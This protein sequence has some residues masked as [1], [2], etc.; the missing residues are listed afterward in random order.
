MTRFALLA[1][2]FVPMLGHAQNTESEKGS[3]TEEMVKPLERITV[4]GTRTERAISEV[5]ATV[6]LKTTAD[7]ERELTRDIADLVRFEP[8]VSVAGTGSRFGLSGFNIRGIGGN[9]VLTLVDGVRVPEEFSFGPYLSARRDFVD[10]D[11]L[12]RVEIAR[13]PISS[14]Y[15][16]DA[17]GGVVVFTTKGP[18][19]Y[20]DDGSRF[21]TG[22]K[23]GYS[24][25]DD[26]TVG[27]VTLATGNEKIAGL[28]LYT[29]RDGHETE[30]GGAVGGTGQTRERPNPQSLDSDNLIAK[31]SFNPSEHH[32]FTF[33]VDHFESNS[34][35]RILS[36]YGNVS[37]GTTIDRRDAEDERTRTR[38][39]LAYSY[40]GD[41]GIADSVQA[42]VYQ[43]RSETQQVTAEDRTTPTGAQ[44]IR[45]RV[46]SF[47]Q[48]IDGAYIQL[49]KSLQLLGF[50]HLLTY[51]AEY[52]K[53]SN[54]GLRNGGTVDP[55]GAT[56]AEFFPFPT[57]DFPPTEVEQ[58]A[59]F[60][61]DE[62]ALFEGRLLLSPGIR[63]DSFEADPTADPIY[64][65]GN[66][67]S[68]LP[69]DYDDAE[70]TAKI[71]AVYAFSDNVSAYARY[72]E[73][74]RAPPYDDVNVGFSNFIGGYKTISNPNLQS[75]RST[76]VELGI[77]LQGLTGNV[78]LAAF[79]NNYDNFIESFAIAPEFLA[80]GGTDPVDGLLTFQSINRDE[81]DINGA[82]LS[83]TLELSAFNEAFA[84]LSLQAAVAYADG[85]DKDSGEPINS[86]E[87]LTGVLGLRYTAPSKRWGTDLI[88]TLVNGKNESDIDA[89]NPRMATDDYGIVDLLAH[90]NLGDRVRVNVGFFN[91]GDKSY[92]RWADTAAIGD[93]APGRFTQPG[94]NAGAD[95]RVEF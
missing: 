78:S 70:V 49:G 79:Q 93:D 61:Q 40:N 8:G 86:I 5:A 10:I 21:Y 58:A 68:P 22:F 80:S 36:D 28:V 47:D 45:S 44:E 60:L 2:L 29:R 69:E 11:S 76:G 62:I 81:V 9:R 83:G 84:G 6:S 91:L 12:D 25:A 59:L 66:P 13:G 37:R 16:S 95:I 3:V 74:F 42:T 64:L 32:Q 87:P 41:L 52:Y 31:L 43:Q 53:T 38:L 17:L 18:R 39:S 27:T 89:N 51:G 65:N 55:S 82:E 20:L 35:T 50:E 90:V 72:S 88:W 34:D 14:L 4:V 46:S 23:G 92:I 7:L 57:R 73:G 77:R 71:G 15:G 48:D 85:E 94:F 26:S 54:E 30:N 33:G 63:Y 56:V 1:C 24:G 19:D 67:G 75:E